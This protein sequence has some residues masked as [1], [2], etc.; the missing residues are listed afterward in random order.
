MSSSSAASRSGAARS[1]LD[2][3]LV[4]ELLVL[5]L[6]QLAAAQAVDRAVLRGRHQPGARVVGHA[7]LRPV[8]ERGDQRV[9]RQLLGEADVAHHAREPGDQPGR[10]DPPDRVDRAM[11]IG[12]RHDSRSEQ[13]LPRVQALRC[14][15][16]SFGAVSIQV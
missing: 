15:Y 3:E 2:L 10:L 4:A 14:G 1:L 5:A 7:R 12:S 13:V 6:E 8:L 11:G 16:E 9:L